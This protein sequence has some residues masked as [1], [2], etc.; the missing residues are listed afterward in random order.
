MEFEEKKAQPKKQNCQKGRQKKVEASSLAELDL[1]LKN[2]MLDLDLADCATQNASCSTT[3]Q[4]LED[5][6]KVAGADLNSHDLLQDVDLRRWNQ[7]SSSTSNYNMTDLS[8]AKHEVINLLSPSPLK[9]SKN[10][11]RCQKSDAQSIEVINLSDSENDMSAE[12]NRKAKELRLFL[13]S[14]RNDLY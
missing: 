6:T 1:R 14:I 4:S 8:T 9:Q 2:L 5:T 13:A 11:S 10:Y 12:H 7:S 3:G